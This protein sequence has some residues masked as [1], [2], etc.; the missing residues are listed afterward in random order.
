[1]GIP[2]AETAQASASFVS[3]VR[4]QAYLNLWDI[5]LT[6]SQGSLTSLKDLPL[7]KNSFDSTLFSF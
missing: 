6:W 3:E 1:M 7:C 4:P 5:F 2:V